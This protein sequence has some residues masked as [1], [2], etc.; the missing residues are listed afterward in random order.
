M[1]FAFALSS[2]TSYNLPGVAEGTDLSTLGTIGITPGPTILPGVGVGV[3][4]GGVGPGGVGPGGV[5]P[6]GVGPGGVGPGGVGP[7][8]V[9]PGGVGS[10]GLGVGNGK[11][12]K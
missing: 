10:G 5:G 3:G 8:G 6:G 2:T 1:V 11:S 7:G 4:A 12:M 9:G